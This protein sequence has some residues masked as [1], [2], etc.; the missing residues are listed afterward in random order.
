MAIC[1]K[2]RGHDISTWLEE[3][4]SDLT[5]RRRNELYT[6]LKFY[7]CYVIAGLVPGYNIIS[8]CI[9][10]IKAMF[11]VKKG[12][13]STRLKG[14]GEFLW[15]ELE[16][17]P[18]RAFGHGKKLAEESH[19][20]AYRELSQS[21]SIEAGSS[22]KKTHREPLIEVPSWGTS[23]LAIDPGPVQTCSEEDEDS[24][25]P[26][27]LRSRRTKGPPVITTETMPTKITRR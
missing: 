5:S 21:Q 26:L 10:K 16:A 12:F 13:K 3:W 14:M 17:D 6:S 9:K 19:Q 2:G 1:T 18:T 24:E 27:L 22:K 15:A 23:S 20:G 11:Q 8:T 4:R 7:A 25:V